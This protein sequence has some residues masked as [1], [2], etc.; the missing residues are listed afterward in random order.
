[1]TDSPARLAAL[2][3]LTGGEAGAQA[4][5]DTFTPTGIDHDAGGTVPRTLLMGAGITWVSDIGLERVD[6]GKGDTVHVTQSEADRLDR[7]GVTTT[8]ADAGT[9]PPSDG[10]A[11]MTADDLVAVLA[12]QP[13]LAAR[14]RELEEARPKPRKTVL[15]A[16]DDVDQA[17][18]Q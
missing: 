7:L 9:P 6:A 16:L 14:I 3:A 18:D 5:V 15:A 4:L 13:A 1:M 12:S 17:A 11:D 10:L 2:A 8:A